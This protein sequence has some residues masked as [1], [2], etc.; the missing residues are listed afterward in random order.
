MADDP[1]TP[2]VPATG[3]PGTPPATGTGSGS[4]TPPKTPSVEELQAR[5]ADL[6]RHAT[7][8]TEEAARHGKSLTAAEKELAAYKEKERIASEATLSEIEKSKKDVE[9]ATAEKA[10]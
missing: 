7:N 1:T 6:E 9:R 3:T 2:P 8:K 5:I 10:V 4:A